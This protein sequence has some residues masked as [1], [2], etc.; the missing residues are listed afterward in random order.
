MI[1]K[2]NV[3]LI[4]GAA[5]DVGKTAF[6]CR[7]IERSAPDVDVVGIKITVSGGGDRDDRD[8]H[9]GPAAGKD[10]SPGD[11]YRILED[12]IPSDNTDTGRMLEAGARRS[13][14]L[15]ATR[16]YLE[17]GIEALFRLLPDD[18]CVVAEGTSARTVMEPGA[19]I[20]LRKKDDPAMKDSCAAVVHLADKTAVFDGR[21]W[22]F[23]PEDCLFLEGEWMVRPEAGAIVLAGGDS[24]R[25]GQDKAMLPF[26]G[27]P[28]IAHIV[29]QLKRLFNE[30]VVSA[31]RPEAYRFLKLEIIPDLE[32]G[33]GPLM[34]IASSLRRM[35]HD[36]NFVVACDVP[37]IDL[38]YVCRL[39]AL[40]DGY[41]LVLPTIED[42]RYE[43]L[44]ALYRKS[45]IAPAGRILENGGRS[46]LSLL[47]RVK[48]RLVR[49]PD[50]SWYRNINTEADYARLLA[51]D[52]RK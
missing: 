34:G 13:Y 38:G 12:P 35:R 52:D 47:D 26:A 43:P 19:F 23:P 4:G 22:D 51:E 44:F 27:K 5:R 48:V 37:R 39:V 16:E 15:R 31:N 1:A 41:D 33:Q 24:L 20:V 11:R 9:G 30:V 32:P 18:A 50:A 25:I 2:K 17:E 46:I 21:S 29:D 3:L 49:I 40:A 36:L 10:H 14:W 8:R 42:S 45:I 28:M 6:A 7:I